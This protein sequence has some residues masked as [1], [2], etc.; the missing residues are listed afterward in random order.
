M[1][2]R[3]IHQTL[4]KEITL[5]IQLEL[6]FATRSE[7]SGEISYIPEGRFYYWSALLNEKL[8][9]G[10]FSAWGVDAEERMRRRE[11]IYQAIDSLIA[12]TLI[13]RRATSVALDATAIKAY[14]RSFSQAELTAARER[15]RNGHSAALPHDPDASYGVKTNTSGGSER[16]TV[17]FGYFCHAL[18]R[19]PDKGQAPA[20]EPRLIESFSLV[21]ADADCVE[22]SLDAID[23]ALHHDPGISEIL[24]DREYSYRTP[25]RWIYQLRER[26]IRQVADLHENDQGF[27]HYQGIKVAAG[28]PH[29]PATPDHLGH[30]RRP[31]PFAS[32]EEKANFRDQIEER[33]PY[34]FR[35]VTSVDQ[36]GRI[37]WECPAQAGSVG[38]PLQGVDVSTA[39]EIGLPVVNADTSEHRPKCCTQR[40]V[41]IDVADSQPKLTQ[42]DYWGS[43][44]WELSYARRTYIEGVF[45]IM[46]NQALESVEKGYVRKTGLAFVTLA[47][48]IAFVSYNLRTLRKWAS[49]HEPTIDHGLTAPDIGRTVFIEVALDRHDEP[50]D[51]SSESDSE[52]A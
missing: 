51:S 43:R 18:V 7:T 46:K 14:S 41:T 25:E 15:I 44:A 48:G 35:R 17:F 36:A 11:L 45:G 52:A 23:R 9:F 10:E 26:E 13:A 40:T 8:E 49:D 39:R 42:E 32:A 28:V 6:G 16:H 29:C 33:R 21:P 50:G 30:I 19:V 3:Q 12:T 27:R 37:R 5:E 31:S 47:V 1:A 22:P 38:C 4:T 20:I 34:A 24:V 2:I